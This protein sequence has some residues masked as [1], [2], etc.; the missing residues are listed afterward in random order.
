MV[1]LRQVRRLLAVCVI[2]HLRQW[3]MPISSEPA[4]LGNSQGIK[5]PEARRVWRE[6]VSEGCRPEHWKHCSILV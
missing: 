1:D 6:D 4:E 2:S 5:I 3:E